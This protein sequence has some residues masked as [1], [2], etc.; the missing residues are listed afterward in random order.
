M[1]PL[2][3]LTVL[4]V[5]AASAQD[6]GTL[7]ARELF[8]TPPP[9]AKPAEAKPAEAKA[10]QAKPS[11]PNTAEKKSAPKR[12]PERTAGSAQAADKSA[13]PL[14]LRYSVLKR[15]PSGKFNEVDPDS[16]FRSGDRIRLQ[17]NVNTSGYL[18]VVMQ[19]S[20]GNWRLLFPSVEVAGGSN[21]IQRGESRQI[22]S[23]DR[24]QFV[25][26]EQA[27]IEKLFVV[28]SKQPESNL[29]KLIYSVG[30]PQNNSEPPRTLLAQS[31]LTNTVV[32]QLRG[33]VSSRDLLFEKVESDATGKAENAAYVVNPSA[34][35]D[36]R[37]VV[38]IALKHR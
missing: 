22:P 38:D 34:A 21:R 15:D 2:L 8:Y 28:L 31:S 18:Y 20:S 14:G 1:K 5:S 9:D 11:E 4:A 32:D 30:A 25:F 24:G 35:R 6:Q 3:A 12:A 37:L 19:G 10:P 23:G 13:V 26:D 29:D 16:T 7:R 33:Q 27:G 17:V 36:A